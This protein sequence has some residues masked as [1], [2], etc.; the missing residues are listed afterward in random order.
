MKEPTLFDPIFQMVLPIVDSREEFSQFTTARSSN[1][2]IERVAERRAE[3]RAAADD[4]FAEEHFS[5]GVF[6]QPDRLRFKI[7]TAIRVMTVFPPTVGGDSNNYLYLPF[8]NRSAKGVESHIAYFGQDPPQFFVYDWS[9]AEEPRL[10]RIIPISALARFVT[11]VDALGVDS[12]ALVIMNE[13]FRI[14]NAWWANWVY[15]T[16]FEQKRPYRIEAIYSRDYELPSD[17]DQQPSNTSGFWGP[18]V[19]TFQ[20]YAKDVNTVGQIDIW[21]IQDGFYRYMDE[22]N[23]FIQDD[24]NGLRMVQDSPDRGFFVR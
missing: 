11:T 10:K 22:S 20:R 3:M 1:K 9:I 13:T 16:A 19:E 7:S 6:F 2:T 17:Q 4:S 18:E 12:T 21:M 24:K 5:L 8:T 23:T 15:L 14:Q